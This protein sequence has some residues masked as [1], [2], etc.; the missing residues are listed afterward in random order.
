MVKVGGI[1][2][3]LWFAFLV[4]MVVL[5]NAHR[6]IGTFAV[7]LYLFVFLLVVVVAAQWLEIDVQILLFS[8]LGGGV[9][10]VLVLALIGYMKGLK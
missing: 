10:V 2:V 3:E 5:L 7:V 4:G 8:I 1:S 6:V 9:A